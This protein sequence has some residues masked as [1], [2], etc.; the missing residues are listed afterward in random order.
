MRAVVTAGLA[1]MALPACLTKPAPPEG[2]GDGWL[3]DY[4]YRKPITVTPPTDLADF[5]VSVFVTGD[6]DLAMFADDTGNDLVF[7]AADGDTLLGYDLVG[8]DRANGTVDAW[9]HLPAIAA[10]GTTFYLYYGGPPRAPAPA[11][12]WPGHEAVWHMAGV[13][14]M[15]RDLTGHG[16]DMTAP[17]GENPPPD[18]G[19]VGRARLYE[20]TDRMCVPTP[21]IPAVGTGSFTYSVVT[22][23]NQSTGEYDVL[24]ET[25]GG[26]P[27]TRGFGAELGMPPWDINFADGATQVVLRIDDPAPYYAQWLHFVVV[28]DRE[29]DVARLYV[30]GLEI[31]S[32]S[33]GPLGSLTGER[34]MCLG[35]TYHYRGLIDEARLTL[36][37]PTA[38]RVAAEHANLMMRS[39]FV[40]VGAA[41][42]Q[43]P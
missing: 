19:L 43:A 26:T 1:V 18:L 11:M 42:T 39:S 3:D 6:A 20:G 41:E 13:G 38:E 10:A 30:N 16:H 37:V 25:G 23:T 17:P 33:I 28:A 2:G 34:A 22:Y 7:T 31:R 9:V 36:S 40:T 21:S 29:V 15:E 32:S 14:D 24:F 4:A 27:T 12:A 5:A 35:G 8:F